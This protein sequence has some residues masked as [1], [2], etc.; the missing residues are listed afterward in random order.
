MVSHSVVNVCENRV[1]LEAKI[2]ETLLALISGAL[3]GM[4]N[5]FNV[6]TDTMEEFFSSHALACDIG[7]ILGKSGTIL[8]IWLGKMGLKHQVRQLGKTARQSKLM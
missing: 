6:S 2:G 8:T 7:K 5:A 4:D 3:M 1:D